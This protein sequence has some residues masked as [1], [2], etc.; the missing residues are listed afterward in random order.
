MSSEKP[1]TA[2]CACA[3]EFVKIRIY[4]IKKLFALHENVRCNKN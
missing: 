2:R 3:A 1:G 4:Q